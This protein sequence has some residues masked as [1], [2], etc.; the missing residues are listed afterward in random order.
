MFAIVCYTQYM[1]QTMVLKLAP[2]PEQLVALLETLHAFNEACNYAAE[3]AYT[4]RTSNKFELQKL[5][6]GPLRIQYK[7]P[8]QLAIRESPRPSKPTSATSR[9][10]PISNQKAQ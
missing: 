8:A 5:V 7:L 2:T 9:F 4:T 6:Y 3:I 1:K 10:S